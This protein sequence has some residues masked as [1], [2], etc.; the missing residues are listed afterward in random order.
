MQNMMSPENGLDRVLIPQS[1]A[2]KRWTTNTLLD[3]MEA[4]HA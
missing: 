1:T 3:Q 2:A 4:V